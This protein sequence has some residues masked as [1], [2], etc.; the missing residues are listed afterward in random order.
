LE[1][2]VP[3]KLVPTIEGAR[4]L[5]RLEKEN[6]RFRLLNPRV[7]GDPDHKRKRTCRFLW[8][9]PTYFYYGDSFY[10]SEDPNKY[11][12]FSHW[13]MVPKAVSALISQAAIARLPQGAATGNKQPLSF[14]SLSPWLALWAS[15]GLAEIVDPLALAGTGRRLRSSADLHGRAVRQLR[16]YIANHPELGMK[17]SRRSRGTSNV[18]AAMLRLDT[19]SQQGPEVRDA[20]VEMVT[21][22]RSGQVRLRRI[23]DVLEERLEEVLDLLDDESR[24]Q[25]TVEDVEELAHVALYSPAICTLRASWS[26]LPDR[27]STVR[28]ALRLGLFGMRSF[29]HAEA[30]RSIVFTHGRQAARRQ[31]RGRANYARH[32]LAYC[33]DAHFQ[34]V[35]DEYAWLVRGTVQCTDADGDKGLFPHLERAMGMWTGGPQLNRVDGQGHLRSGKRVITQYALAFGDEVSLGE[36]GGNR[37]VQRSATR[38]AFNS[39]FWP[40]VLA[41]TS[42]G[43]EGLDFH[44]YCRDIVHWNLP[45][46]PVDL[47]QREGRINRYNGL[48]IRRNMAEDYDLAECLGHLGEAR[49]RAPGY[50]LWD[51]V[52]RAVDA[53]PQGLQR[54]KHGLFPHWIYLSRPR[55]AGT[56]PAHSRPMI[57]RHLLFYAMSDDERHYERLKR[58]LATYRLAF[59]QP[60]QQDLLEDILRANPE[61]D[62]DAISRRMRRY[63]V[64]LSPMDDEHIE[65]WVSKHAKRVLERNAVAPFIE[66]L[67]DDVL[68]EHGAVLGCV[69]DE[70]ERL[71]Q[72]ARDSAESAERRRRALFALIYLANPYDKSFDF[73]EGIGFE[74][75]IEVIQAV[76]DEL[77]LG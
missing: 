73:L 43:Q 63:M 25:L 56:K 29:F 27:T 23:S 19:W 10:R 7:F 70:I 75:D 9:R 36:T 61:L 37:G 31:S 54:F 76:S 3:K 32:I 14:K 74:D 5:A 55:G 21:H 17:L 30:A 58:L 72:V 20:V 46:N 22:R 26:V 77:G 35:I 48:F 69:V 52:F 49:P 28:P 66:E 44:L 4:D 6:A 16:K 68:G 33:R 41:T 2:K 59:G 60:R 47:E 53:R 8:Q 34:S 51:A 65:K 42:V 38:D 40:F 18:I 50:N 57:R 12:L 67:R 64:N 45:A 39:P 11:L 62:L 13:R 24:L 71:V 1:V 15:P